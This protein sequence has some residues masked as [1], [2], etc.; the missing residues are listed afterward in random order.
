MGDSHTMTSINPSAFRSA[1]NISQSAEPY[2]VTYHKLKEI[3]KHDKIDTILLGFSYQNISAFNDYKFIEAP[4]CDELLGRTYS[5]ITLDK[6]EGL[7]LNKPSYYRSFFKNMFLLPKQNHNLFLG[8]FD[9]R[10]HELNAKQSKLNTVIKMHYY[11]NG[12]ELPQ[13]MANIQY[14]DSINAI[15]KA[16]NIKLYLVNTPLHNDYRKLIPQKI[17]IAYNQVKEDFENDGLEVIDYSKYPIET[18]FFAD[19]D[20]LNFKG[21]IIFTELIKQRIK[22]NQ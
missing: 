6:Y 7:Q 9:K 11:K 12:N 20:H 1:A 2:F 4:W 18:E 22:R 8:N 3:V 19:Y 13:S 15:T 17:Q 21:S 16:N 14:L 10:N 5:L